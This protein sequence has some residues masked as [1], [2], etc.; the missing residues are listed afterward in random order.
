[1]LKPINGIIALCKYC[2]EQCGNASKYCST[3]GT[4][5][6]RKKIFEANVEIMKENKARG[7]TV[8]ETLKTWK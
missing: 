1:M 8:P 5:T 6:G 4:Q 3:C 7:M 2:G